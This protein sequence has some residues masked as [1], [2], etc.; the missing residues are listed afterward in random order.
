MA[1]KHGGAGIPDIEQAMRPGFSGAPKW[2][3]G[4]GF[5]TGMGLPN[6]QACADEMKL[7]S[8]VGIGTYLEIVIYTW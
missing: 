8:G 2:A 1:T 7:E 6:I 4:L 5:G 3:Q